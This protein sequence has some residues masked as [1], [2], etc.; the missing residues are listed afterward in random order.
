MNPIGLQFL[1]FLILSI[2]AL[3]IVLCIFIVKLINDKTK[4][5]G[6][7]L[8]CNRKC[9]EKYDFNDALQNC[10]KIFINVKPPSVIIL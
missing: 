7:S 8:F 4:N 6:E 5:Q 9:F 1:H 10:L 3:T 2:L